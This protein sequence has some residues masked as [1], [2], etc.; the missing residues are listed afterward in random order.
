MLPTIEET[1]MTKIASERDRQ[2]HVSCKLIQVWAKDMAR[3][4]GI[5]NFE[6]SRGWLQKFLVRFNLVLRRKTTTGQRLPRD[7]V[8]K[9]VSFVRFCRKQFLLYNFTPGNVVNMD[10]TLIWA[11]MPSNTTVEARG[12][13]TVPIRTTGNE[14]NGSPFVLR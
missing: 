12:A 13:A 11:D 8:P 7:F 1:L 5:D 9:I 10:E 4:A 2:H 3:D 14:K 6:A